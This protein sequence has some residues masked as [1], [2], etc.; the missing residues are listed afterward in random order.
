MAYLSFLHGSF[1]GNG[2]IRI[3][4]EAFLYINNEQIEKTIP[5][6]M[7]SKK[8]KYLGVNLMKDANGLFKENTN[9]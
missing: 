5:F 6:K 4:T 2:H 3:S 9:H 7:A 1:L 8:I